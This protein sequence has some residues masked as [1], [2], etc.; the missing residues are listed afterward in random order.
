ME[1]IVING[2][3]MPFKKTNRALRRLEAKGVN[4]TGSSDQIA[5]MIEMAYEFLKEGHLIAH[6]QS[7][8]K[9]EF[10]TIDVL[11][12]YDAEAT[13]S[14][15]EH[16]INKITEDEKKP[17]TSTQENGG[18]EAIQTIPQAEQVVTTTID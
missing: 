13:D 16:I 4:M 18:V 12:A 14:P 10:M 9:P 17:I 7:I 15:I 11:E 8:V 6:K 2:V 1:S 5:L 3:D